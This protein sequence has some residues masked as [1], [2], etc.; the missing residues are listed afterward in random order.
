[1]NRSN[2]GLI[3]PA[4][5]SFSRNS[6]IVRAVALV[7][8]IVGGLNDQNLEHQNRI[9][10]RPSALGAVRIGQRPGQLGAEHL[11]IHRRRKGQQLV[12]EVA[13]PLQPFIDIE[14]SPSGRAS[15]HPPLA[16]TR[17]SEIAAN[18]EVLRGV[19]FFRC[20]IWA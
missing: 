13:Q 18:G 7:R 12:A 11:K 5:V 2:S 15:I 1:L 3:A 17:E 10:P 6:Q 8:Q 16:K 19:H 20:P 14:K 4:L 9:E